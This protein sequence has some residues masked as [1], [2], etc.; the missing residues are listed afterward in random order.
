MGGNS[1]RGAMGEDLTPCTKM[2]MGAT[3]VVGKS[4]GIPNDTGMLLFFRGSVDF[5]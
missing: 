4:Y 2:S 5:C 3:E 1:E